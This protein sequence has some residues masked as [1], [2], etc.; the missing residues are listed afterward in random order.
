MSLLH[1]VVLETLLAEGAL[2]E[3]DEEWVLFDVLN[4]RSDS[5]DGLLR[6]P[7]GGRFLEFEYFIFCSRHSAMINN[8]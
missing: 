5:A 3:L 6:K 2:Q 7:S 1:N 8:I 4:D